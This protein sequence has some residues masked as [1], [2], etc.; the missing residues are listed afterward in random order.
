MII[1]GADVP[2]EEAR[3]RI[4]YPLDEPGKGA[5]GHLVVYDTTP[6]RPFRPHR[7]AAAEVWYIIEG[8]ALVSLDG[9]ESIVNG[10]DL[11]V[12]PP[13]C[14]HGLRSESRARWMCLG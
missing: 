10:G 9:A 2:F 7:H 5:I 3:G 14:E 12:L 11:V 4:A 13:W 1:R 8:Q 6:E